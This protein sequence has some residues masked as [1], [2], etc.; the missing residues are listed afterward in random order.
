MCNNNCCGTVRIVN[1]GGGG[2]CPDAWL[3]L[4]N[5]GTNPIS[6]GGSNG[7]GTSDNKALDVVTNGTRRFTISP[8]DGSVRFF[9]DGTTQQTVIAADEFSGTYPVID[10][11]DAA[12]V[13]VGFDASNDTA[14]GR[15]GSVLKATLPDG[16]FA[17]SGV[18]RAVDDGD[19][20]QAVRA[21]IHNTYTAGVVETDTVWEDGSKAE[22]AAVAQ[23]FTGSEQALLDATV[24]PG[25]SSAAR[26]YAVAPSNAGQSSEYLN[27]TTSQATIDLE[28]SWA[29][30]GSG[31]VNLLSDG[32]T[33]S[34]ELEAVNGANGRALRVEPSE[35]YLS[36]GDFTA[37][38]VPTIA[39]GEIWPVVLTTG[40]LLRACPAAQDPVTLNWEVVI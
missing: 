33:T 40:N 34:A 20:M 19:V 5:A 3:E 14:N 35:V 32:T 2:P 39:P 28:A 26:A 11:S 12:P 37:N 25:T 29:G 24:I 23:N 27:A 4:L 6:G 22:W 7:L 21:A 8:T 18:Q 30:A 36:I 38:S 15:P 13:T 17:A 16:T 1:T 10:P 31:K 9:P